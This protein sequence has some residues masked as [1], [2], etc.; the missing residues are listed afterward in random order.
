MGIENEADVLGRINFLR[1]L[2][3]EIHVSDE[4]IVYDR[5]KNRVI[6]M[7]YPFNEE[8]IEIVMDELS[9]EILNPQAG[10]T[11]FQEFN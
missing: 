2:K 7:G 3:Y 10:L 4:S 5:L 8:S 11:E 9:E 1:S 6:D